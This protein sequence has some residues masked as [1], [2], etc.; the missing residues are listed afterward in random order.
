MAQVAV[1]TPTPIPE[2]L[3]K[4]KT[5]DENETTH[6]DATPTEGV[7]VKEVPSP[8]GDPHELPKFDDTTLTAPTAPILYLPPLLSSL[9]KGFTHAFPP[10]TDD[11]DKEYRP[12]NTDTRLPDIDPASLA[13]HKALHRFRPI[14]T[15]YAVTPYNKAFNWDDMQLPEDH[16][17]EWYCVV[18]R[19][20]R[21]EGSDGGRQ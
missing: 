18:F 14:T 7:T 11:K 8:I 19:S 1:A 6:V 3:P 5:F 13:L 9:P 20:K 16:E 21:K 10:A 4:D 12:L 17:R 15:E 2:T